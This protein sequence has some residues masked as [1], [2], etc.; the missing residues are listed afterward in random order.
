MNKEEYRGSLWQKK[1]EKGT[2]YYS[3]KLKMGER[4]FYLTLFKNNKTNEK[5]PDLNIIVRDSI[6]TQRKQESALKGQK[7]TELEQVKDP[8]KDEK[9]F[10]Q[11]YMDEL[12]FD[13]EDSMP[14]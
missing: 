11:F 8:L 12:D 10:E 2:T 13:N 1:S 7:N 3:G 9:T 6:N 14:F 4:E 5:Q